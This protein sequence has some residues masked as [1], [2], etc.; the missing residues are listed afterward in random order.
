MTITNTI[1]EFTGTSPNRSQPAEDFE[2]NVGDFLPW[3]EG[4][5]VDLNTT[6]GEINSTATDVNNDAS[7]ATD[8]ATTA[9]EQADLAEEWATSANIVEATDYS[10]KEYAIGTTVESAKRHAS[11]TVATGSA[12]DWASST[13]EVADGLKGARGYAQD[14][15]IALSDVQSVIALAET[16]PFTL[17]SGDDFDSL[18]KVWPLI[19]TAFETNSLPWKPIVNLDFARDNYESYVGLSAGTTRAPLLDLATFSRASS[20]TGVNAFGNI[21]TVSANQPRIVFENGVAKGILL[22]N[23]SENLLAWSEDFSNASWSKTGISIAGSSVTPS[24]I[25]EIHRLSSSSLS[26]ITGNYNF[27]FSATSNGVQFLR[28]LLPTTGPSTGFVGAIFDLLNS[29][30][31]TQF[32]GSENKIFQSNNSVSISVSAN[33]STTNSA[34]VRVEFV[35]SDGSNFI[36]DGISSALIERPQLEQSSTPSSYI[37]T[38]GTSVVRDSDDFSYTLPSGFDGNRDW[39]IYCEFDD[40]IPAGSVPF[41][42]VAGSGVFNDSLYLSV[43]GS[44]ISLSSGPNVTANLGLGLLNRDRTKIVI[45]YSTQTDSVSVF[46]DGASKGSDASVTMLKFT[47]LSLG[48]N[49]WGSDVNY[50]NSTFQRLAIFQTA[51]PDVVCQTITGV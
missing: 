51:L 3:M 37:K 32:G 13:T 18:S 6:I 42:L 43:T 45:K 49:P 24:A 39:T 22:E 16:V 5:A 15:Q 48:T 36:G 27:S 9:T 47:K 17:T 38:E 29:T 11:G 21:E 35:N 28:V 50:T 34:A 46:R 12:K 19:R 31:V 4:L 30:I 20:G 8:A 1:N 41:G 44:S 10:S 2:T 14:S 7:T 33:M 23:T 26:P 40:D 25:D